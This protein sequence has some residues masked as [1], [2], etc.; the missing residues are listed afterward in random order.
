MASSE[1]VLAKHKKHLWPCITTYYEQPIV[2]EKALGHEVWDFEGKKYLDFFGGILTVSVGGLVRIVL[3]Q[4][5][6]EQG[7]RFTHSTNFSR[8]RRP[9]GGSLGHGLSFDEL[10][11]NLQRVRLLQ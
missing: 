9:V 11:A 7:R 5:R 8:L 3:R 6:G 4:K 10:L 2:V 1:E